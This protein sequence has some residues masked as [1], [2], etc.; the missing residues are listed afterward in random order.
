MSTHITSDARDFAEGFIYDHL[1]SRIQ[2]S[3]EMFRGSRPKE[4]D[5]DFYL[6]ILT[7]EETELQPG[8]GV[9]IL[10][11]SIV[12]VCSILEREAADHVRY[13]SQ[14]R[15][16]LMSL[17]DIRNVTVDLKGRWYGTLVMAI[18]NADKDGSYGDIFRLETRARA[19]ISS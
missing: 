4:A 13:R 1:R 19:I 8:V 18:S 7:E 12:L 9:W 11:Q 15:G 14:V 2:S 6:S 17:C 3:V 10:Q 5:P 16:A